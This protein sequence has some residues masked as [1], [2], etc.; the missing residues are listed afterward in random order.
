M[1]KAEFI[2]SVYPVVTKEE[3][4]ILELFITTRNGKKYFHSTRE[5]DTGRGVFSF[6]QVIESLKLKKRPDKMS[7]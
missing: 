4:R 5:A 7:S 3:Q 1:T 6:E 2:I